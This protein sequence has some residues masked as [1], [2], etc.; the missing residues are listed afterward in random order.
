MIE[1][2]KIRTNGKQN[3]YRIFRTDI[4]KDIEMSEHWNVG[5]T[6]YLF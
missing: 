2:K 5:I 3:E 6:K 4:L 1:N